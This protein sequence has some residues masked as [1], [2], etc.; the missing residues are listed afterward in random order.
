MIE[1]LVGGGTDSIKNL[2]DLNYLLPSEF[3]LNLISNYIDF[4]ERSIKLEIL[5]YNEIEQKVNNEL[6]Y[7]LHHPAIYQFWKAR[8]VCLLGT[9]IEKIHL[10]KKKIP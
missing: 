7:F 2:N 5:S 10:Q 8:K 1:N 9:V 4:I 3:D 6:D